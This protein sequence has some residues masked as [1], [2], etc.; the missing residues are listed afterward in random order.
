VT[1]RLVV[2]SVVG[3]DA[4]GAHAVTLG[5]WDGVTEP[6]ALGVVWLAEAEA[7]VFRR[8]LAAAPLV[9]DRGDAP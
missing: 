8:W 3:P 6:E 2:F 9:S 5:V 1:K 4:S 7:D